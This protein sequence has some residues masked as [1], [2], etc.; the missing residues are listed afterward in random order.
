M[1]KRV[2]L[3]AFA[4]WITLLGLG[5]RWAASPVLKPPKSNLYEITPEE[6]ARA[7]PLHLARLE[8]AQPGFGSYARR[9]EEE[10]TN[11]S[12]SPVP[13]FNYE[14]W[15]FRESRK[16]LIF[17]FALWSSGG[18][19]SHYLLARVFRDAKPPQ[20]VTPV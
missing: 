11:S 15:A 1:N 10:D 2:T 14:D 3:I 8:S 5:V 9:L 7:F 13:S 4:V 19:V 20:P 17:F 16:R 12:G 18:L 6:T